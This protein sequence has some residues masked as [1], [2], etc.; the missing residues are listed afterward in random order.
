ME[1][2]EPDKGDRMTVTTTSTLKAGWTASARVVTSSDKVVTAQPD[3]TDNPDGKPFRTEEDAKAAA[4]RAAVAAI[5]GARA[6]GKP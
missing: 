5:I 6:V 2:I 1:F 4:L 3:P